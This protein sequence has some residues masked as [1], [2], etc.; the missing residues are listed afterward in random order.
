MAV[1]EVIFNAVLLQRLFDV[2]GNLLSFDLRLLRL[3]QL[4]IGDYAVC[5]K[6]NLKVLYRGVSPGQSLL[7]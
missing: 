7:K 3:G 6:E 4:Y 2:H 5:G 1:V